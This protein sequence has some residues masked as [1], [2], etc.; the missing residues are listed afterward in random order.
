MKP[1]TQLIV[2][3]KKGD[4]LRAAVCSLLELEIDKV[5]NFAE[6]DFF[7]GLDAWLAKRNQRFIRIG[8]PTGEYYKNES[9]TAFS[10]KALWFGYAGQEGNP[11]CMLVWGIG[12]RFDA[13][14]KRRQHVVVGRANGY[15]VEVIHDPHESR[16]G[17]VEI[18]GFGWI[19]PM[20][21]GQQQ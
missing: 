17:L 19:V 5:P 3:D 4:C 20:E 12:P 14:G 7:T 6:L 9:G 8:I 21:I 1:V 2:D 10:H 15:G 11:D 13:S 18:W 16:A